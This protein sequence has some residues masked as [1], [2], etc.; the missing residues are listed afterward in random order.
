M[1][2]QTAEE[3]HKDLHKFKLQK[4]SL[5]TFIVRWSSANTSLHKFKLRK[6]SLNALIVRWSSSNTSLYLC[7]N[8]CSGARSS[9]T[10]IYKFY[11]QRSSSILSLHAIINAAE[12]IK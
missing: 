12:L 2:S 8:N 6:S 10:S 4:S 7:Y 11:F 5:N 1:H 3:G 9:N